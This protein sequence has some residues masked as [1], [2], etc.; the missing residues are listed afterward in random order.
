MSCMDTKVVFILCTSKSCKEFLC[1]TS[2]QKFMNC[3]RAGFEVY[4]N[5][6]MYGFFGGYVAFY[7][8]HFYFHVE[9]VRGKNNL[10]R[11]CVNLFSKQ[12]LVNR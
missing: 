2:V 7:F 9:S 1:Q 3:L 8:S 4:T 11:E 6:Y 10:E 12:H 5:I